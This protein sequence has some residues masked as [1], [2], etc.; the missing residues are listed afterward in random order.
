MKAKEVA[1][2]MKL[3]KVMA[4]RYLRKLQS[5][6]II[7]SS[8]DNPAF[9]KAVPVEKVVEIFVEAKETEARD[10]KKQKGDIVSLF[11][12]FNAPGTLPLD[13]FSVISRV[14]LYKA[15]GTRAMQ[16]AKKEIL[17]MHDDLITSF[18]EP[19]EERKILI[20]LANRGVKIRLLTTKSPS[21]IKYCAELCE[22]SDAKI[23]VKVISG[24]PSEIFPR[25]FVVDNDV[26]ELSIAVNAYNITEKVVLTNSKA[27]IAV[28]TIMFN[29]LW[30]EASILKES[31]VSE[32]CATPDR[33]FSKPKIPA[34]TCGFYDSMYSTDEK[35][36]IKKQEGKREIS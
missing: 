5:Q 7:E 14:G 15:I 1:Q 29:R 3:N 20:K 13:S 9:F 10:I 30:A 23:C 28:I 18:E 33:R 17:F 27:L 26:L 32:T 36:G 8:L 19:R 22:K 16:E 25:I 12:T 35:S 31:V 6:G 34:N 4:Y 11:S 24:I 21:N 2:A